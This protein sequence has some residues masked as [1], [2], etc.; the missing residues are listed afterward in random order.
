MNSNVGESIGRVMLVNRVH[1]PAPSTNAL[2]YSSRGMLCSAAVAMMKVNPRPDQ[3]MLS[4]TAGSAQVPSLSRPGFFDAGKMPEKRSDS[5]PTW[6]CSRTNQISEATA[7]LVTTVEEKIVRNTPMPRRCLSA[8][9]ARP[10][11]PMIPAGTVRSASW[12]VLPNACWNSE[13]CSTSRYWRQPA[14]STQRRPV[15]SQLRW[16]SH[17]ALPSG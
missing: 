2:S 9:T 8:N 5:S 6:G 13:L 11:P 15:A 10:T 16:P 4:P 7:T 14:R 1:P 17:T 3:T 12:K